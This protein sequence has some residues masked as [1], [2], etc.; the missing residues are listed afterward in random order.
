MDAK[1]PYGQKLKQ[2]EEKGAETTTEESTTEE[3]ATSEEAAGE[4]EDDLTWVEQTEGF[5]ATFTEVYT[6]LIRAASGFF[7]GTF[8]ALN[9]TKCG[10][11]LI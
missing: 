2:L 10:S 9:A 5:R 4:T 8:D 7:H 6:A 11:R 3:E 1:L